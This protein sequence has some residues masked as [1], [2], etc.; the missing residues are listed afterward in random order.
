MKYCNPGSKAVT[1]SEYTLHANP[2]EL[3]ESAG[4]SG[5][6]DSRSPATDG[7]P[8]PI[9]GLPAGIPQQDRRP[10]VRRTPVDPAALADPG[11]AA[12]RWAPELHRHPVSPPAARSVPA[13]SSSVSTAV[14]VA[15][16][17]SSETPTSPA[18][19]AVADPA[20]PHRVAQSHAVMSVSEPSWAASGGGAVPTGTD[21]ATAV[22]RA[23]LP[24]DP[25]IP[26]MVPAP[27]PA[28]AG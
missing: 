15:A 17:A 7:F 28:P 9:P 26:A 4:E 18:I 22:R 27:V 13:T 12:A 25:F 10:S 5:D 23:S 2:A 19:T 24:E 14:P 16:P 11:G 21:P 3:G 20:L 1:I 8:I 6:R